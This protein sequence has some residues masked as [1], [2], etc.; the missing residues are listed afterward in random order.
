MGVQVNEIAK[1]STISYP[2]LGEFIYSALVAKIHQKIRSKCLVH[3]F[4]S[5]HFFND[6]NHGYRAAIWKKKFLWLL[7]FLMAVATCCYHEK[8]RR[9]MCTTI[10]SYLLRV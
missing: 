8:M 4:S 10:V 5:S 7:P 3:E 6:I 9:T 1:A 2:A